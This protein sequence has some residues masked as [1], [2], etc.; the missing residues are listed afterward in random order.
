MKRGGGGSEKGDNSGPV[1]FGLEG[2]VLTPDC[3]FLSV[4]IDDPL[5]GTP[6]LGQDFSSFS[7]TSTLAASSLFSSSL[8]F[9]SFL[10]F[11]IGEEDSSCSLKKSSGLLVAEKRGQGQTSF[12]T[13]HSLEG[14]Q[15]SH[16]TCCAAPPPWLWLGGLSASI[17]ICWRTANLL[18]SGTHQL[19]FLLQG[20]VSLLLW[21]C[22]PH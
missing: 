20:S 18:H 9:I 21:Q 7:F 16:S 11:K 22:Q 4:K 12:D 8:V 10:T 15:S 2:G 13:E 1:V 14:K 19:L 5:V 3:E 17:L 6:S